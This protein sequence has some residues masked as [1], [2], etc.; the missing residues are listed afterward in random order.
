LYSIVADKKLVPLKWWTEWKFPGCLERFSDKDAPFSTG[1]MGHGLPQAVGLAWGRQRQG[2]C[3]TVWCLVGDGEM[4][5]GSNWEALQMAVKHELDNFILIVDRNGLQAMDTTKHVIETEN[6][7][8]YSRLAGFGLTLR[9]I[10]ASSPI[11]DLAS[12]MESTRKLDGIPC[13][14]AVGEYDPILSQTSS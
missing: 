14:Q 9:F 3:G 5:E 13:L 2:L 10:S 1:S 4:Q 6:A 8:L 12:L 7:K 11:E